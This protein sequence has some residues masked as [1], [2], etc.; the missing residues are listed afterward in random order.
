MLQKSDCWGWLYVISSAYL[1]PQKIYKIGYTKKRVETRLKELNAFSPTKNLLLYTVKTFRIPCPK[2]LETKLHKK[3]EHV[4]VRATG[5]LEWFYLDSKALMDLTRVVSS[6]CPETCNCSVTK[7]ARANASKCKIIAHFRKQ[8]GVEIN[9][10][11]DSCPRRSLSSV[12]ETFGINRTDENNYIFWN[13]I[14][15]KELEVSEAVLDWCG[16]SGEYKT[17]KQVFLRLL[18]KNP[19]IE[20]REIVVS[21]NRKK[22]HIV[23]S[24]FD[25]ETLLMQMRSPKAIEIREQFSQIKRAIAHYTNY[26]STTCLSK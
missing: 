26:E 22:R 24:P 21:D 10:F 18:K 23:I 1:E 8:Q 7:R 16:Y 4:K 12:L 20:Y 9:R 14:R 13:L 19:H 2:Q 6:H 5:K 15:Q 17:K 25:F 3:F 11:D